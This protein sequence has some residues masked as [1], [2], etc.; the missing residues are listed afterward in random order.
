ML[1]AAKRYHR[2]FLTYH[3]RPAFVSLLMLAGVMLNRRRQR[4]ASK[5]I[6]LLTQ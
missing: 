1:A 6:A 4:I 3:D 5:C 2:V